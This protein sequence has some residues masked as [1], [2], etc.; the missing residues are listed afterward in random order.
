M[1]I[2]LLLV[3]GVELLL[4]GALRCLMRAVAPALRVFT[5]RVDHPCPPVS[6]PSTPSQCHVTATHGQGAASR[7]A[8]P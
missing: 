4:I 7:V 6:L 3:R 1:V 8:F 2:A 5:C